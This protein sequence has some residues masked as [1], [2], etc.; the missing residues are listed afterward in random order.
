[1]V[2]A[3]QTNKGLNVAI[4]ALLACLLLFPLAGNAAGRVRVRLGG[5]FVGGFYS[6]YEWGFWPGYYWGPY[7][8]Y[9]G[10]YAAYYGADL[11]KIKLNGAD[12]LDR[13][14]I[15]GAYAGTAGELKSIHLKPGTYNLEVKHGDTS[16]LSQRIYVLSGKTVEVAVHD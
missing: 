11:G 15:D 7:G 5:G 8:Y 1:M 6:P 14:Y 9:P 10:Y 4:L 2:R 12:K 16:I 3:F 13:V